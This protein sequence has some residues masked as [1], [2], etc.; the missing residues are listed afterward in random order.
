MKIFT[1]KYIVLLPVFGIFLFSGCVSKQILGSSDYHLY[2]RN[3]GVVQ[4]SEV[5]NI[6]HNEVMAENAPTEVDI[7]KSDDPEVYTQLMPDPEAVTEENYVE[8]P[9]VIS[10]KYDDDPKFYTTNYARNY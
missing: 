3:Y 5:D 6:I 10:Y 8:V 7:P 2:N 1:N 4:N 9:P